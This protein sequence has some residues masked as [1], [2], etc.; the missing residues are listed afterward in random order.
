[1]KFPAPLA[2]ATLLQRYKRFLVDVATAE[3]SFTL[4]CANTGRMTGCAEPGFNAFYSTSDNA[5]RKYAHSLEL[6]QNTQG[7]MI[8]VNTSLANKICS[9]AISQNQIAEL[10]GYQTLRQEVKYGSQ[11]SRI[12]ILLEDDN[13]PSC[14][15]EVKSV[16][17]LEADGKGYFPDA[18]TARGTKHLQELMEMKAQGFRAV[19]LFLV[20]HTGIN[21]VAAAA[22][23][24]AKYAATLKQA[25][26]AGVEIL[27]YNTCISP[28]EIT[29]NKALKFI[30]ENN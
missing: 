4:H 24:D 14:Y 16:T 19:L 20:Q 13:K 9:E 29:L 25:E 26:Q 11:N 1:M 18:T 30:S 5:K 22:H 6:T 8:C 3:H 17:L 21:Q 12:D 2:R 10:V 27:C 28:T 15:I 7:D 23:I